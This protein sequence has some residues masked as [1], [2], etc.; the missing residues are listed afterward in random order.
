LIKYKDNS[1]YKGEYKIV[2]EKKQRH[3]LGIYRY[4]NNDIFMGRW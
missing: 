3:G 1:E 2:K 4:K